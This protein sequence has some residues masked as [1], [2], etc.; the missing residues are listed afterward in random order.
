MAQNII[1]V[2][3]SLSLYM[4]YVQDQIRRISPAMRNVPVL[5]VSDPRTGQFISLSYP[6][7]LSEVQRRTA[8]GVNEAVKHA[9]AIGYSVVQ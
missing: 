9:A 1:S 3:Q 4:A 7:M 2:A 8:L 6:Q 5:V